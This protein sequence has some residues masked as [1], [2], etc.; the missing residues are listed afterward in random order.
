MVASTGR[1]F[2]N[3]KRGTYE[4]LGA[5]K[6]DTWQVRKVTFPLLTYATLQPNSAPTFFG[7]TLL[8]G[9]AKKNVGTVFRT[10]RRFLS[11]DLFNKK[12]YMLD[13]TYFV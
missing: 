12:M 4:N 9:S 11:Y 5:G 2:S 13:K 10:P 6:P 1:A 8:V 3:E 7:A